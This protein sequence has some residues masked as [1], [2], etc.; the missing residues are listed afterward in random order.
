MSMPQGHI[1]DSDTVQMSALLTRVQINDGQG[2]WGESAL[3]ETTNTSN[4]CVCGQQAL[5]RYGHKRGAPGHHIQTAWQA[6]DRSR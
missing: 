6:R 4:I 1:S 3:I 2:S 5:R